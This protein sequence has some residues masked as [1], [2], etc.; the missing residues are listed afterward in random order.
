MTQQISVIGMG[1]GLSQLT[2]EA[3]AALQECDYV[4]AASKSADDGLLALRRRLHGL[5]DSSLRLRPRPA[6]TRRRHNYPLLRRLV[7]VPVDRG[8]SG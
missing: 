4:I 2:A 3:V 6:G 1:M 5:G 7:P 8:V